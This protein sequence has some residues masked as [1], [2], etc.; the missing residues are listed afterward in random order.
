MSDAIAAT[1]KGSVADPIQ[2]PMLHDLLNGEAGR[3]IE[4]LRGEEFSQSG[5]VSDEAIVARLDQYGELSVALAHAFAWGNR[6]AGDAVRPLWTSLLERVTGGV[7]RKG[8][9][10]IWMDLSH[11]PAVLLLYGG[12]MGAL[13]G[14]RFG[15]FSALLLG[16][17][18]FRHNRWHRAVEILI[19]HTVMDPRQ[20]GRVAGLP[21]TFAPLSDRLAADLRPILRDLVP[22][23][24]QFE[25]L[26]DRWEYLLG[27]IHL[28]VT[29][30]GDKGWG[31]AGRFA[32]AQYGTGIDSWVEDEIK[33]GGAAWGPLAAGLF[34]GSE[35]RL[36]DSLAAW[37]E[38]LEAVRREARFHHFR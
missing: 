3:L 17:R 25:R 26:F 29:R 12:G 22:D 24:A 2:G 37:R 33:A 34:G 38:H 8:G 19:T 6:W 21:D 11:Y 4:R 28:D 36:H 18:V 10:A 20:A 30:N 27:L 9:E 15:N 14:E 35:K 23:D 5:S 16:P 1:V 13:L 7:D 32:A 31:P